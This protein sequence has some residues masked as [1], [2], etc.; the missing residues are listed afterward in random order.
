MKNFKKIATLGLI[1]TLTVSSIIPT[2]AA[3]PVTKND[4]SINQTISDE[5]KQEL[6]ELIVEGK[7]LKENWNSVEQ[8]NWIKKVQKFNEKKS[9]NKFYEKIK[10]NCDSNYISPYNIKRILA[11]LIILKD[12]NTTDIDKLITEGEKFTENSN[13]GINIYLWILNVEQYNE[14]HYEN[15]TY[16]KLKKLCNSIFNN[17][18]LN[19]SERNDLLSYLNTIKTEKI[20]SI[21]LDKIS[22][23]DEQVRHNYTEG[24]KFDKTG[25]IIYGTYTYTYNN[26]N[27]REIVKEITDYKIDTKTSLKSGVYN[28]K[29]IVAYNNEQHTEKVK[30]YVKN[31]NAD[32]ELQELI[33]K[34]NTFLDD[35]YSTES[36]DWVLDVKKYNET[37]NNNEY[38]EQLKHECN[39]MIDYSVHESDRNRTVAYLMALQGEYITDINELIEIGNTL[40]DSNSVDSYLWASD[41]VDSYLWAISINK[42]NENNLLNSLYDEIKYESKEMIDRSVYESDKNRI[43]SYLNVIKDEKITG[44]QL[45]R[46]NADSWHNHFD[47]GKIIYKTDL[48]VY[49]TY[50]Y[51][52]DNGNIREIEKEITNYTISPN[53]P[54]NRSDKKITITV[55]ENN[56][57]YNADIDIYVDYNYNHNDDPNVPN[58]QPGGGGGLNDDTSDGQTRAEIETLPKHSIADTTKSKKK[59]CQSPKLIKVKNKTII[60][61]KGKKGTKVHI[62]IGKKTYT[63]KI[64]KKRKFQ[65]KVKNKIT[66]NTKIIVWATRKGYRSSGQSTWTLTK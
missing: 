32:K 28:V 54:L 51:T 53:R 65:I 34:G 62:R 30:I 43:I 12:G 8:L 5:E 10:K 29:I 3:E 39:E 20:T 2:Y 15:S 42:Y 63:K 31:T 16:E 37:H 47:E 24:E 52:Y 19:S 60:C 22:K 61:G 57:T 56:K 41:S 48:E 44:I 14:N 21:T 33:N 6:E 36:Y 55:K 45:D 25:L 27:K 66:E 59:Q 1:T 26:G 38:Y 4:I 13:Y 50:I 64:N 11:S 18:F 58:G 7:S 23:N 49:G 9:D 35:S 46:I 17:D 40:T